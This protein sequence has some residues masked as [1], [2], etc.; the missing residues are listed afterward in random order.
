[1]EVSG[2][3]GGHSVTR[4]N[5]KMVKHDERDGRGGGTFGSKKGRVMRGVINESAP[6][7]TTSGTLFHVRKFNLRNSMAAFETVS[8]IDSINEDDVEQPLS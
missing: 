7:C 2:R 6:M 1:M 8:V 4:L 3:G 5:S